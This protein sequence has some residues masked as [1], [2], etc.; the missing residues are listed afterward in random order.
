MKYEKKMVD[1]GI[2]MVLTMRK[3]Q[4]P[5]FTYH[6]L[7]LFYTNI[8]GCCQAEAVRGYLP[9]SIPIPLNSCSTLENVV[10]QKDPKPNICLQSFTHPHPWEFFSGNGAIEVVF[11][12]FS[13]K[14]KRQTTTDVLDMFPYLFLGRRPLVDNLLPDQRSSRSWFPQAWLGFRWCKGGSAGAEGWM[15]WIG[16]GG[17]LGLWKGWLGGHYPHYPRDEIVNNMYIYIYWYIYI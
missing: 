9:I 4:W 16:W 17:S 7:F 10:V 12:I 2:T 6:K 8:S 11:P 13:F 14:E 15:D 1:Y 5:W 3:H